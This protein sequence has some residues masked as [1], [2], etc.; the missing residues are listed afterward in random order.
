METGK[1]QEIDLTLIN[2][3]I[4]SPEE[5]SALEKKF[6]ENNKLAKSIKQRQQKQIGD[7]VIKIRGKEYSIKIQLYERLKKM[8]SSKSR[9]KLIEDIIMT[10][11]PLM[12]L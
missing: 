2:W 6:I 7:V 8:K 3:N 9:D 1:E 11:T 10:Y 4:L 5:F 12:D